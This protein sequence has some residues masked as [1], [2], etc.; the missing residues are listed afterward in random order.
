MQVPVSISTMPV[1]SAALILAFFL[2]FTDIEKLF[3]PGSSHMTI[4][5]YTPI[6]FIKFYLGG[7]GGGGSA[8][9]G[10]FCTLP[11]HDNMLGTGSHT[12]GETMIP[13]ANMSFLPLKF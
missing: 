11:N 7:G 6:R 8:S 4:Q 13:P 12:V 3:S 10:Q 9:I 5:S 1:S 2:L